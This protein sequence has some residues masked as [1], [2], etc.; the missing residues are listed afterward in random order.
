M[1]DAWALIVVGELVLVLGRLDPSILD[2]RDPRG[3]L[4][5]RFRWPN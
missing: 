2:L 5:G 3:S 1:S 4:R